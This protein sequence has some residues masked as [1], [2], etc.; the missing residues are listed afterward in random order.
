MFAA[1]KLMGPDHHWVF[2][3]TPGLSVSNQE[4]SLQRKV[5]LR[6]LYAYLHSTLLLSSSSIP[7]PPHFDRFLHFHSVSVI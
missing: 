5:M 1:L 3:H 2:M 4:E 6:K 7:K